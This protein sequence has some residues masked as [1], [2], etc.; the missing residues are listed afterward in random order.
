MEEGLLVHVF[1]QLDVPIG[2]V[3]EAP[4]AIVLVEGKV[5][6]N[7]RVP[8]GPFRFPD[9]AHPRF[10]GRAVGLERVALDA[11]AHHIVRAGLRA[12]FEE[13]PQIQ[14]VGEAGD[15]SSTLREVPALHPE[16]VLVDVRLPDQDGCSRHHDPGGGSNRLASPGHARLSRGPEIAVPRNAHLTGEPPIPYLRARAMIVSKGIEKERYEPPE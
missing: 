13:Y 7:E 4:P 10:L 15:A 12:I 9:E 5:D 2:E 1:A 6:L 14:V 8:L 16:V 3:D 11:G